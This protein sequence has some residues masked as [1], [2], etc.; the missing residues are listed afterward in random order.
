VNGRLCD[1]GTQD[2]LADRLLKHCLVQMVAAHEARR[3]IRVETRR[4]KDPL[5]RPP[6]LS[7]GILA[8]DREGQRHAA[9]DTPKVLGVLNAHSFEV[10]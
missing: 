9:G 8:L 7:R 10:C 4:R 3:G 1:A 6:R 2:G 5:A